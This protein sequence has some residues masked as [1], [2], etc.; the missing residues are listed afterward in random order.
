MSQSEIDDVSI[1]GWAF[2]QGYKMGL[3][4][5]KEGVFADINNTVQGFI[6]SHLKK[7][8]LKEKLSESA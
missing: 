2:E 6:E 8:R 3:S 7:E 4:D 5:A 1:I